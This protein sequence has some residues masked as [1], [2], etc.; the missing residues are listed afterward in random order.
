MQSKQ[1]HCTDKAR[2]RKDKDRTISP[3]HI[4]KLIKPRLLRSK[5]GHLSEDIHNFLFEEIS[6]LSAHKNT[7]LC[8]PLAAYIEGID[9]ETLNQ[10][11]IFEGYEGKTRKALLDLFIYAACNGPQAG[12]EP[13]YRALEFFEYPETIEFLTKQALVEKDY[14]IIAAICMS[15]EKLTKDL[16]ESEKNQIL[17]KLKH[18]LF[19]DRSLIRYELMNLFF[20]FGTKKAVKRAVEAFLKEE[21]ESTIASMYNGLGDLNLLIETLDNEY[22]Q[23]VAKVVKTK[24]R[25]NPSIAV[26]L[27]INLVSKIR[28]IENFVEMLSKDDYEFLSDLFQSIKQVPYLFT[29]SFEYFKAAYNKSLVEVEVDGERFKYC[30]L[31]MDESVENLGRCCNNAIVISDKIPKIFRPIIAYHEY[32]EGKTGSHDEAVRRESVAARNMGLEKELKE[33]LGSIGESS[34]Y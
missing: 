22:D 27:F 26:N 12:K 20:N 31:S 23:F 21:D 25:K 17:E 15:L 8:L 30:L 14:A 5:P 1:R 32:I 24:I 10:A 34:R 7:A 33:W 13:V 16:S 18:L 19:D 9:D 2:Q 28:D 11:F 6:A 3:E 4:R 29:T